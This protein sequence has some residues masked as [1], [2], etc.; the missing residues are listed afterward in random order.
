M[1]VHTSTKSGNCLVECTDLTFFINHLSIYIVMK[2]N[3]LTKPQ[4]HLDK[5]PD[6]SSKNLLE[7]ETRALT[8]SWTGNRLVAMRKEHNHSFKATDQIWEPS[9]VKAWHH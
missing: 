3:N 9:W 1:Y 7:G 2:G 6:H 5:V 8:F 4:K